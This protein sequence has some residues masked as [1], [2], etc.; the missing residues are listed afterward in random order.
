M[1]CAFSFPKTS[2]I[3]ANVT[4][5]PALTPD[6]VQIFPSVTHLARATQ[7]TSGARAVISFHAFLFVVARLPLRI[8]ARAASPEPVHTV[9]RYCSWGYISRMKAMVSRTGVGDP[10]APSPPGTR[11]TSSAGGLAKVCVGIMLWLTPPGWKGDFVVTGS[12]VDDR[13]DRVIGSL[14]DRSLMQLRGPK[15]SR[16]SKP[17]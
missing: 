7:F 17:G 8:P 2:S 1:N 10:R 9:I 15:A 3:Q 5:I 14:R 4:S 12:R 11:R 16:A 6:E 13:T